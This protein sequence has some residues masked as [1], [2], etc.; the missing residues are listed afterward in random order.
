MLRQ[1]LNLVALNLA[2][3]FET[4][5]AGLAHHGGFWGAAS[6]L[7]NTMQLQGDAFETE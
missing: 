3:D 6:H 4:G 5:I 1:A 7:C 2:G